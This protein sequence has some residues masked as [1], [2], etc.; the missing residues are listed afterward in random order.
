[1]SLSIEIPEGKML[2]LN[3][4]QKCFKYSLKREGKQA[5]KQMFLFENHLILLLLEKANVGIDAELS[6]QFVAL[7]CHVKMTFCYYISEK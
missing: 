6:L 5:K 3:S 2:P 1:M 7:T 4:I